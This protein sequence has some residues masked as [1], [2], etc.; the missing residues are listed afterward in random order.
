MTRDPRRDQLM[1]YLQRALR[2]TSDDAEGFS[3]AVSDRLKLH[4]T[5]FR[6]L[7]LLIGGGPMS[8][9]Q[10]AELSGLTA[11]GVTGVID[12]LER[13]G[14]V[15]RS[16]AENDRRQVQLQV[17]AERQP[18]L[19]DA[20]GP[21]DDGLYEMGAAYTNE[22]LELIGQFLQQ[23][24]ALLRAETGRLQTVQPESALALRR[25][26]VARAG[27][28]S[29]RL[30]F[31]SGASRITLRSDGKLDDLYRAEFKGRKPAVKADDDGVVIQYATFSP[32][33][34]GKAS[35][36]LDLSTQV[37]WQLEFKGGVSKLEGDLKELHL[38]GL[39][40]T[41]GA[42]HIALQLPP[43]LQ[44]SRIR[45]SGGASHVTLLRPKRHAM[46]LEIRGGA[47]RVK[48]DDE[49]FGSVGGRMATATPDFERSEDRYEIEVTGGASSLTVGTY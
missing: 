38:G 12:R 32:F 24:S 25:D 42:S 40:I 48:V 14:W 28:S 46:R 39:D 33:D 27:R 17:N 22:Q 20:I 18:E 9:G 16:R 26:V 21:F 44:A 49:Q 5:D 2:R 7:T 3:T 4:V 15:T 35:A 37:R 43:P 47:S 41:G 8:A 11:G 30:R 45:I 10:L 23:T 29:A 6:C 1:Q 34:W 36:V 13:S 31:S 19:R